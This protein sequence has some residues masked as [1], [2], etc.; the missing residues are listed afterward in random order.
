[1]KKFLFLICPLV[2]FFNNLF[3]ACNPNNSTVNKTNIVTFLRNRALGSNKR[4]LNA[5]EVYELVNT[6]GDLPSTSNEDNIELILGGEQT[7]DIQACAQKN[8]KIKTMQQCFFDHGIVVLKKILTVLG[9]D[10]NNQPINIKNISAKF[11]KRWKKHFSSKYLFDSLLAKDLFQEPFLDL[12]S[13]V[14]SD[15]YD[16]GP[17]HI[18]RPFQHIAS[19]TQFEKIKHIVIEGI[20]EIIALFIPVKEVSM[21]GNDLREF[22]VYVLQLLPYVDKKQL[23]IDVPPISPDAEDV[24]RYDENWAAYMLIQMDK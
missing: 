24:N 17:I 4:V 19:E 20:V 15:S 1:M 5:H 14:D 18:I 13:E 2:M 10:H 7:I 16:Y 12:T 6:D 9:A 8:P 21:Q 23:S 11:L 3:S 22:P